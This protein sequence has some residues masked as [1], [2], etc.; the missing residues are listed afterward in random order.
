MARFTNH[1]RTAAELPDGRLVQMTWDSG[2]PVHVN[3]ITH[4]HHIH[5]DLAGDLD[6]FVSRLAY[7]GVYEFRPDLISTPPEFHSAYECVDSE[8]LPLRTFAIRVVGGHALF[9]VRNDMMSPELAKELTEFEKN[10]GSLCVRTIKKP[11]KRP[12]Q[13]PDEDLLAGFPDL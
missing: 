12:P 10:D 11:P 13:A 3:V 5:P 8:L 1:W 2:D 7:S 9:I 6:E 4:E